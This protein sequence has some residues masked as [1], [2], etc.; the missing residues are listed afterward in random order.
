MNKDDRKK[1]SQPHE[2]YH[3]RRNETVYHLIN[4][5]LLIPWNPISL[6]R[7]MLW[8][9]RVAQPHK[10]PKGY[11][12]RQYGRKYVC[13]Q[14]ILEGDMKVAYENQT[15]LVKA[16]DCVIIP[17]GDSTISTGPSGICRKIYFIPSGSM[18]RNTMKELK[19]DKLTIIHDF[20]SEDFQKI[21]NRICELHQ[22]HEQST[23]SELASL[24]F[25]L[26]M[27]TA[28]R[29]ENQKYPAQLARCLEF[30]GSNI[31]Q[32]L[33]LDIICDATGIGKTKL[34]KLFRDNLHTSPGCYLVDFRL[35][36][37]LKILENG[38]GLIKEVALACGY[39]N[40]LYF[41]NA[42]KARFGTSPKNYLKKNMP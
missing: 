20:L 24:S 11:W 9:D 1:R 2:R 3:E 4:G 26:I 23:L 34:K 25:D 38:P 18:F 42:F 6:Y 16:G 13:V 31:S 37:A 5:N 19:F 10:W 21:F 36:N 41:S 15:C 17:P 30:I 8:L 12:I 29:I 40:P 32:E 14:I 35:T 27:M 7:D 28:S 39:K 22:M 33:S